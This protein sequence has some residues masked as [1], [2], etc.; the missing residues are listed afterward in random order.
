MWT[1]KVFGRSGWQPARFVVISG[2]PE[3]A[4]L[5]ANGLLEKSRS[6]LADS[7]ALHGHLA[8]EAESALQAQTNGRIGWEPIALWA[9]RAAEE[10]RQFDWATETK[11]VALD[12]EAVGMHWTELA[13]SRPDTIAWHEPTAVIIDLGSDAREV[14]IEYIPDV[15]A[16]DRAARLRYRYA[17]QD[18]KLETVLDW[19][20]Y[21]G[22]HSATVDGWSKMAGNGRGLV[23]RTRC[24]GGYMVGRLLRRLTFG[25]PTLESDP[26]A[27]VRERRAADEYPHVASLYPALT[28]RESLTGPHAV[29]FVHGTVSCGLQGL[30]D[31]FT[32]PYPVLPFPVR[33]FE[34]D[35]FQ[36]I[37]ANAEELARLLKASVRVADVL[38]AA[39]SRGGLVARLTSEILARDKSYPTRVRV[40]TF[41]TPHA[42]TPLVATGTRILNHL[43]KIG[44]WG[45]NM[46]APL[47][48]PLTWAH[49]VL[50]DAPVLP[51]GIA[52][53]DVNDAA[54]IRSNRLDDPAALTSWGSEFDVMG[55]ASGFGIDLENVLR[56]FFGGGMSDLVV[57]TSSATAFGTAQ[58][59]LSCS[60]LGYFR[61]PE[62][63]A[64]LL[65]P[66]AASH[67]SAQPAPASVVGQGIS[68]PNGKAE[69]EARHA[70]LIRLKEQTEARL[71]P[72]P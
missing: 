46:A 32:P 23:A 10:S 2:A 69:A 28:D 27:I 36:T 61:E 19:R 59:T 62:V 7:F 68:P 18:H 63:R 9:L 8:L 12:G 6:E 50:F 17:G 44:E 66:Y 55:P 26:L 53:M 37:L 48:S 70:A 15:L 71:R 65:N 25:N 30:K 49:G 67:I 4:T 11:V 24:A 57:E 43:Y 58:R 64:R 45:I 56:G 1:A 33:R 35:T 47:L 40:E 29:V 41:G 3:L 42:G 22:V 52:A 39:H 34:H 5:T 54:L 72:K 13:S 31:A 51:P 20:A 14:E 16:D 21:L 38:L 60:H